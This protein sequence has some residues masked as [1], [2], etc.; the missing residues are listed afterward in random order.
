RLAEFSLQT[1]MRCGSECTT[2]RDIAERRRDYAQALDEARDWLE[3]LSARG[4]P[5]EMIL[6]G[7]LGELQFFTLPRTCLEEEV[8]PEAV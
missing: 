5:E 1:A 6:A 3:R 2:S 8:L 4:A 7:E